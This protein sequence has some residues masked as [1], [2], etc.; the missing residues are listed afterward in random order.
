M[1]SVRL[2][3]QTYL[4]VTD[5]VPTPQPEARGEEDADDEV[6]VA[7]SNAGR[8]RGSGIR[9]GKKKQANAGV[10]REYMDKMD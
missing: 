9:G 8:T 6:S 4:P 7:G 3:L 10:V 5:L 2:T 1:L